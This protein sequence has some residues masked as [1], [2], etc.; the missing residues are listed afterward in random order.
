MTTLM[1]HA[2][3]VQALVAKLGDEKAATIKVAIPTGQGGSTVN[4]DA[5]WPALSFV[6]GCTYVPAVGA[7]GLPEHVLT[8]RPPRTQKTPPAASPEGPAAGAACFAAA[9]LPL[10]YDLP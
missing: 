5:E 2:E 9:D 8:K 3:H 10:R 7:R 4:A 6:N 1:Q